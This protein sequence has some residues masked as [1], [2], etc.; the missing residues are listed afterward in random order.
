MKNHHVSMILLCTLALSLTADAEP[1]KPA[2]EE[3]CQKLLQGKGD[4]KDCYL[5]VHWANRQ[6][7][8]RARSAVVHGKGLGIWKS[9]TQFKLT[10]DEIQSLL[11]IVVRHR[12][13]GLKKSYGGFPRGGRPIRG[14]P[15]V[16]VGSVQVRIGSV[17]QSCS[18]LGGG[19]QSAELAKLA[20][21]LLTVCE[22]AAKKN[23]VT[24]AT[25]GEGIAKLAN[26]QLLPET[27]SV[28]VHRVLFK[29]AMPGEEGFLMR[30]EGRTV[31]TRRRPQKGMGPE[32]RLELS[33]KEFQEVVKILKENEPGQFP[34]N[35]WAQYYTDFNVT[36]LNHR[37]S[38]QARQFA[39]LTPKTH[40]EKQK[41]FDRIFAAMEKLHQ[42]VL[43]EGKAVKQVQR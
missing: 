30:M 29:N 4:L 13:S 35:L 9:S 14:A 27:L 6:G 26:E 17:T 5:N 28:L 25:L 31:T 36:I 21:D 11:K 33:P 19:V 43:K 37:K 41:Q 39:R 12:M 18:Q 15:E 3:Q 40:G 20:D 2:I 32:V 8:F 7:Q 23:P 10:K 24:A 16:L 42:K 22:N 34:V 1:K 38:M